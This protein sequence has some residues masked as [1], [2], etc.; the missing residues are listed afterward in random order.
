MLKGT[1][2]WETP[3]IVTLREPIL[4][5]AKEQG[6]THIYLYVDRK[7]VTPKDYSSF[8]QAAADQGMRV[9]AL[10][11]EPTWGLKENRRQL[12]EFIEWVASYN[13]NVSEDERFTGIHL[14]VEPYLLPEWNTEQTRVIEEWL[15]NM[16]FAAYESKR[17]GDIDLSA[18]V[19]FW[20]HDIEV[21]GY[22]NLRV[23]TW[24]LKRFDTLVLMNYRDAA[25]GHDG[26]VSNALPMLDE[27]S[28][29]GKAVVVGVETA[30][31]REGNKTT[32]YEEGNEI[33]ERE[34][35]EARDRLEA[36]DG[37]KGFAIHGFPHWLRS[38]EGE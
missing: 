10:G 20:V 15:S 14:D 29:S 5:F 2:I 23:S 30:P 9:E 33:M 8:I 32:F 36:Y 26:I 21:P 1:W 25:D 4:N 11:G 12:E 28:S 17:L 22:D 37:F 24:M 34:L 38:A 18:D 35:K 7:R 19:P 31:S 6:V 13:N 27:A 3:D 16:D